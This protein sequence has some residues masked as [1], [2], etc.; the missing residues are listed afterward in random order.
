MC[1]FSP[2]KRPAADSPEAE[3]LRLRSESYC[4]THKKRGR[5]TRS[6]LIQIHYGA[7][8]GIRTRD[9]LLGKETLYQLSYFRLPSHYAVFSG[10]VKTRLVVSL[11]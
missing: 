11:C 9:L 4:K 1:R 3:L 2:A 10:A 8:D 5:A 7:E 6:A